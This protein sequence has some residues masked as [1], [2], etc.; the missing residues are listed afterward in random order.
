MVTFAVFN[1]SKGAAGALA[2]PRAARP[3]RPTEDAIRI[4]PDE[5]HFSPVAGTTVVWSVGRVATFL[6]FGGSH[7]A[8]LKADE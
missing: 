3:R 8:C 4:M 1:V 2:Q 7:A 5:Y 6:D